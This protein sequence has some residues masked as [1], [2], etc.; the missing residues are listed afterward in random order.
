MKGKASTIWFLAAVTGMGASLSVRAKDVTLTTWNTEHLMSES[1][2]KEWV[3]YC[4]PLGWDDDSP[5]AENKPS[6]LTYCNALNGRL[7]YDNSVIQS[8]AVHT[9]EEFKIKQA[10]LRDASKKLNSD[11]YFFQEV[12]D[13]AAI[14]ELLKDERY[15][16]MTSSE[17]L[18]NVQ[19]AQNVGIAYRTDK[20]LFDEPPKI[21]IND[22]LMIEHK[23]RYVR[24][25]IE[26]IGTIN[27]KEYVFLN[28]HLKASCRSYPL[29]KNKEDCTTYSKQVSQLEKWLEENVEMNREFVLVGDFNRDFVKD[30]SL[31][32]R[33]DKN[34]NAQ[35]PL[36]NNS[37][38]RSMLKEIND[39]KPESLNIVYAVNMYERKHDDWDC[40]FGLDRFFVNK[41]FAETQLWSNPEAGLV[42]N[43][44][45]YPN[46][47]KDSIK[48]SDHC[49]FTITMNM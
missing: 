33:S 37:K 11:I 17:L 34:D 41:S 45:F 42:A 40:H 9:L 16:V 15:E 32:A 10:M 23:G 13:A 19:M 22:K 6:Y 29:D 14:K 21:V 2:F 30:W 27:G 38:T 8:R 26:L 31:N 18:D 7:F 1:R 43:A 28:V 20:H 3:S 25:G 44:R 4:E 46:Y 12:S 48:P 24:P 36:S 5:N 35:G 39:N 49:P 47:R